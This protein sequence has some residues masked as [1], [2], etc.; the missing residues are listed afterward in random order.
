VRLTRAKSSTADADWT[1][2]ERLPNPIGAVPLIP[3]FNCP[4]MLGGGLPDLN[5][6]K[7]LQDAINKL[8]ADLI[9][10]SEFVAYPQRWATG[11]EIPRD[12]SG[13]ALDRETFLSSVSR[14]WVS[15]DD[16]A[17]FGE[18]VGADG[19]A[20]I[21]AIETLIQHIAAQTRT[22]PH[23]LLGQSGAFPSGE[24]LKAT[25]TGLV[26]KVKD[27]QITFGETWEEAM[28]LAFAYRGDIER[29]RAFDCETIW[30]DPESRS[31]GELVDSLLKMKTLGVP[32][33]ALWA[34]W[35]ASPQEIEAWRQQEPPTPAEPPPAS[36]NVPPG[37]P[38]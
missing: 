5:A 35:G 22:P 38:S 8:L 17:K 16:N 4:Q 32:P 9:V 21:A 6:V 11:I 28:R 29:S 25:E 10:N 15:E 33:E 26:A 20:Y 12:E 31:E 3:M 1:E 19:R 23:Y 7:P 14:L 13:R 37:Q 2:V 30:K 27:K 36:I 34:R 18:L 24:S